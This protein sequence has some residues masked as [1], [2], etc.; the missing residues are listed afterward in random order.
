MDRLI[1][2]QRLQIVKIYYQNHGSIRATQRAL[3]PIFSPP[4]RPADRVIQ[5]KPLGRF[6]NTTESLYNSIALHAIEPTT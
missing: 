1:P 6:R 5:A 2:E 3:L 4:N